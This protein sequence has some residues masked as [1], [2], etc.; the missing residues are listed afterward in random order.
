MIRISAAQEE[1]DA[2]GWCRLRIEGLGLA[3]AQPVELYFKRGGERQPFLTEQGWQQAQHWLTFNDTWLDGADLVLPIGPAQTWFLSDVA[4]LEIGVR[5]AGSGAEPER[6]RLAWPK[7]ILDANARP[8]V[9]AAPPPPAEELPPPA[10]APEPP[11][12]PPPPLVADTPIVPRAE[13]APQRRALW[14]WIL[15]LVVVLA[16]L[17]LGAAY[18]KHWPPF[19]ASQTAAAVPPAAAP[20]ATPAAT[21]G[22]VFSEDEV[23]KY[24]GANPAAPA[25]N[26]EGQAYLKAGHPDLAL[27]IYR[28]A[29]RKGDPAAAK[30]IGRMYDPTTYSKTT[31]PFDTPDADQAA[32]YYEQA[33][34]AGDIEAEFLLGRVMAKGLTSQPDAVERGVVWLQRAQQGGN[35]EAA[36]LLTQI[37]GG[38]GSGN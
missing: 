13:P 26:D 18:L 28:Y 11:A 33:A 5:P 15:L 3:A 4:T 35:S 21:P 20:A 17:L 2:N 8:A 7:I 22:R 12:A 34:K 29:Q 36:Q 19:A 23:R 10:P 1:T 37:K 24:L 14:P 31:S 30:A 16:A 32:T 25:A 38:S 9:V 27:L 6:A